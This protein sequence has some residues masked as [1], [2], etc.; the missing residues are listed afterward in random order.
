MFLDAAYGSAVYLPMSDAARYQ[1]SI[2]RT[3]L[4]ARPMNDSAREAVSRWIGL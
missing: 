3:G 2:S 1:V 4:V